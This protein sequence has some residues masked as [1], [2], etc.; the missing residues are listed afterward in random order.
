MT[1]IMSIF[2]LRGNSSNSYR[3]NVY[4]SCF[5]MFKDNWLIGIGI[6]NN[7]FRLVYGYYMITGF[8]AL[9]AYSVPLEVAVEMGI[10]GLLVFCWMF[11]VFISNSFKAYTKEH[12]LEAKTII[13]TILIAIAGIGGQAVFD[14][15]W[16]RPQVHILFWLLIAILS[17]I[18]SKKV[19]FKD[20]EKS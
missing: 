8:D 19:I 9:G 11:L 14:T 4:L 20:S 16:Y 7:T 2:T 6:G 3:M 13:I 15:I 10:I 1:G 18:V 12:S 5:E 17:C